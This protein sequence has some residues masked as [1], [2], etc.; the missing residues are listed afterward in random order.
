MIETK[1]LLPG[2]TLRSCRDDRFKQGAS[3][4]SWCAP[5]RKRNPQKMC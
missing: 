3:A 2:V 4:F 5:W 1:T